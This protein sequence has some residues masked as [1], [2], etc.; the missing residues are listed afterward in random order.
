MATK[1]S[2]GSVEETPQ[3]A[4]QSE[5]SPDTFVIL[6]ISLAALAVISFGLFW[7]FGVFSGTPA[8]AR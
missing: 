5:N 1:K 3:E 4:T 2:D 7:Y 6:L 8:P